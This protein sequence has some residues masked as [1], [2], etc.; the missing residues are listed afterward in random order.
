MLI[1]DEADLLLTYGYEA[2]IHTIAPLVPRTC[3]CILMSATTSQEVDLLTALVLHDP[4]SLDLTHL[5]TA[6]PGGGTAAEMQHFSLVRSP[7]P[8]TDS[9]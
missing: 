4:V 8:G 1:L 9:I 2:D 7:P 3:Q 6:A 5:A